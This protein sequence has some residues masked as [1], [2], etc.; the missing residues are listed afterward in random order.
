MATASIKNFMMSFAI[1][2]NRKKGDLTVKG[3][4]TSHP[5]NMEGYKYMGIHANR[6]A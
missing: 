2:E 3:Y 4:E 5:P 6:L 1:K